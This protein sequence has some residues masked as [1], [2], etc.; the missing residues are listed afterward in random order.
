V[1]PHKGGQRRIVHKKRTWPTSSSHHT[2]TV[3]NHR[4]W[5]CEGVVWRL[6]AAGRATKVKHVET[7][8]STH[9]IRQA[10]TL[11]QLQRVEQ[12]TVAGKMLEANECEIWTTEERQQADKEEPAQS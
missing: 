6:I 9:R 4:I 2:V 10:A 1:L 7:R 8:H 12:C 11:P 5:R 3:P